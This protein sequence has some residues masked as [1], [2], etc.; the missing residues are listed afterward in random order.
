MFGHYDQPTKKGIEPFLEGDKVKISKY[1]NDQHDLDKLKEI[2]SD[3]LSSKKCYRNWILYLNHAPLKT[4]ARFP[5][6]F[7]LSFQFSGV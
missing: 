5:I 6:R 1:I 7:G 2:C 3:F 4:L